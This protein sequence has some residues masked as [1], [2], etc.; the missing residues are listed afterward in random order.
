[1]LNPLSFAVARLSDRL[2]ERQPHATA[3]LIE[4]NRILHE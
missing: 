2:N 3:Y 1:L 4:K